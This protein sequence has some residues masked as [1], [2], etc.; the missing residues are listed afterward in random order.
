MS[1][2]NAW[3][4]GAALALVACQPSATATTAPSTTPAAVQAHPAPAPA[5]NAQVQGEAVVGKLAQLT[6]GGLAVSAPDVSSYL[7]AYFPDG[8]GP[9]DGLPFDQS[10]QHYADDADATDPS[11]WPDVALGIKDAHIVSAV[12]FDPGQTLGNGWICEAVTGPQNV[13]ACTPTAIDSARRADWRQRWSAY[14]NTA[15]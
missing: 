7:Q 15:D 13:R 6:A 4:C 8:C 2:R 11:P 14:L 10:C 1:H 5:A 3:L 9:D 12:L